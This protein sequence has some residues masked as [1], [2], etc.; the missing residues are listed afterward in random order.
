MARLFVNIW[1][2]T[3]MKICPIAWKFP[4]VGSNLCPM[5][6]EGLEN[7]PKAFKMWQ[8]W[9]I[10][11]KSGHTGWYVVSLSRQVRIFLQSRQRRC[12][13]TLK[14][15]FCLFFKRQILASFCLFLPFLNVIIEIQFYKSLYGVLGIRTRDSRMEG[16]DESTEH[17]G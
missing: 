10:F 14:H 16:A 3:P 1:P 9:R 13:C 6:N 7:S 8:K 2:L 17:R 12:Q 5:Q 4:K 11:A 15:P